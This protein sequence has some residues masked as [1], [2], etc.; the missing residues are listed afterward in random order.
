MSDV[1]SMTRLSVDL[2]T[3]GGAVVDLHLYPHR[4]PILAL[5]S[6]PVSLTIAP[7]SGPI[8]EATMRFAREFAAAAAQF[9]ADC[10]RFAQT[11]PT[12]AAGSMSGPDSAEI[13]PASRAA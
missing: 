8:G 4:P 3:G 12:N 11:T 13:P 6:L 10:E 9:A 7:P 1:N 5:T 2:S